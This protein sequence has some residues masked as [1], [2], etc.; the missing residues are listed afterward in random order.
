MD[1]LRDQVSQVVLVLARD[2][3]YQ[4]AGT[5]C[6]HRQATSVI[7]AT[8]QFGSQIQGPHSTTI[9]QVLQAASFG[10]RDSFDFL[11]QLC[12]HLVGPVPVPV[13]KEG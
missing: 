7:P 9:V 2:L 5:P 13:N 3:G 8:S 11:L 10:F 4:V 12:Y 1:L 6:H